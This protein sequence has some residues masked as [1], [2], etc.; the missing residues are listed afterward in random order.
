MTFILLNDALNIKQQLTNKMNFYTH[1]Q[2]NSW[3]TYNYRMAFQKA[4]F[5]AINEISSR[6]AGIPI[7]EKSQVYLD[8]KNY[9]TE[10]FKVEIDHALYEEKL[11]KYCNMD[12]TQRALI[13]LD[14]Y[15]TKYEECWKL[16]Q[17]TQ[18]LKDELVLW[19]RNKLI[20]YCREKGIQQ[21]RDGKCNKQT[22][23]ANIMEKKLNRDI[24][25]IEL[26]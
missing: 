14:Y 23:I 22:L 19:S 17:E 15:F 10:I 16:R 7:E 24:L 11:N 6:L 26:V 3:G 21:S 8:N 5:K 9:Y 20:E 13:I 2:I 4:V 18:R 1:I 12:I 25:D